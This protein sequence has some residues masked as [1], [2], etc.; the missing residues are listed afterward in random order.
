M[1]RPL[2]LRVSSKKIHLLCD[3]SSATTYHKQLE[4]LTADYRFHSEQG[5]TT[6]DVCSKQ[7]LITEV[8]GNGPIRRLYKSKS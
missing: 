2:L 4:E 3:L 7:N 1:A 8:N 5:V 6:T